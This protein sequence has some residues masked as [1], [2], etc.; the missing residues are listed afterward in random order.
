MAL[1]FDSWYHN[2][3]IKHIADSGGIK[4]QLKLLTWLVSSLLAGYLLLILALIGFLVK[5]G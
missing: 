1:D 2:E 4:A 3:W 5:Q